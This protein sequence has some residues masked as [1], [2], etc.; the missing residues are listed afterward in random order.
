MLKTKLSGAVGSKEMKRILNERF[1]FD[2]AGFIMPDQLEDVLGA[3]LGSGKENREATRLMYSTDFPYT[4]K[5]ILGELAV[6]LDSGLRNIFRGSQEV[7]RRV[8][9]HNARNLFRL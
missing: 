3:G 7:S 1:Y 4:N 8:Y 6:E 5:D 9:V 2:L